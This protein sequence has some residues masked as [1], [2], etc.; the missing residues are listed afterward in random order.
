MIGDIERIISSIA[1]LGIIQH[2]VEYF[3][4]KKAIRSIFYSSILKA[5]RE[6][7]FYIREFINKGKFNIEKEKQLSEIWDDASIEAIEISDVASELCR[8]ISEMFQND[9]ISVNQLRKKVHRVFITFDD[10]M[11]NVV[12]D[13]DNNMIFLVHDGCTLSNL[14]SDTDNIIGN[15]IE[16][17]EVSISLNVG[18][19]DIAS[20][21]ENNPVDFVRN[22][23][24]YN[25]KAESIIKSMDDIRVVQNFDHGNSLSEKMLSS[26][27]SLK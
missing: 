18:M 10:G 6:T 25:E 27:A 20:I 22:I 24:T 11:A 17:P 13:I 5:K 15:H 3:K 4:N 2:V 9:K 16:I 12:V 26:K 7:F 1:Q 8:N 23:S 19:P 21:F 14:L